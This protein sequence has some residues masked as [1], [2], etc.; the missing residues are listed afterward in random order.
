MLKVFTKPNATNALL[1]FS[2]LL[3]IASCKKTDKPKLSNLAGLTA[4]SIKDLPVSF[5]IDETALKI[6]NVDSLPFQTDISKLVA[7]FSAVPKSEVKVGGTVQV[8]GTTVN[9]FSSP[10]TYSVV[11][12][13][14][15]S[16]R[17][18]SVLVN[19]A[20]IDPK[21]ISWQQI[22]PDAGWGSFHSIAATSMGSKLYMIGGTMGSF[23]AFSITSN[24]S[25]DGTTWTR[26]K[27][28]DNNGDSVPRVE[29]PGFISFNNKLWIIG[30]H[31]PGEGFDWDDVTN[32]VLS[33]SD[34]ISW[35]A[36]VPAAPTDRW[37]KRERAGV[38]VFKNKLWVIGGNDYP[39]FGNT[40]SPG[41]AFNDVW[42]STDGTNWIVAN[43]NPVFI[44]RTDPAVFVYDDK[45]WIAGGKDNGGNYLDEV[46]NS[47]DG[48]TWS[49]V[50]TNT[51]F[52]GRI[53]PKVVAI[54]NQLIMVGGE[55]ADGVLGD[56]WLSENKGVDWK[57]VESGDVRALPTSFKAR[58]EFSMVVYKDAVYIIGGLGVK[59]DFKYAIYSD[60]WKGKLQ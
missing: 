55:N 6:S 23:G 60:V 1:I 45:M 47:A 15:V 32:K 44:P 26:T 58:K 29:H 38:L 53:S 51:K 33:S 48:I 59:V 4:F 56:M 52:T 8:S 16:I 34:G 28:V 14:G 11:A 18:Y 46:W 42:S 24:V 39:S 57:K 2:F 43:A 13:D 54:N 12:E 20:K 5:T 7:Q 19:V 36:S 49:Q 27:S 31:K 17:N 50:T 22:T 21:T 10:V 35:T 40:N 41:A 9:N 25:D 37:S 30:G 3:I